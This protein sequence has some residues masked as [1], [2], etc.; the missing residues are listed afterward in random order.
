MASRDVQHDSAFY[1]PS[2]L[3]ALPAAVALAVHDATYKNGGTGTIS[4]EE[5]SRTLRR[6]VDS[7]Q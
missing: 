5:S 4:D 6:D 3:S 7:L 2:L 1:Q